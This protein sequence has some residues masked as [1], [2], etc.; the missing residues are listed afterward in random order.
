MA[1]D[2]LSIAKSGAR[3]ARVALDVTAQNIANASSEGYV[4]RTVRL[5][6]VSAAGGIGRIGDVSLSGVRST[7]WCA[8]PMSSARPKCAAPVP[9]GATAEVRGWRIS[10]RRWSSQRLPAM[11][12]SSLTATALPIPSGLLRA[13]VV[14]TATTR[15]PSTWP[16]AASM[17]RARHA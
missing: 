3:A 12:R 2:L 8:T 17:R 1:S 9:R 11:V 13:A 14:E 6:E 4:R 15:A 10:R 7:G 16:R 5:E